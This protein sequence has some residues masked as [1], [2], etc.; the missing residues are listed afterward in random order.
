MYEF[1]KNV[2]LFS[3]LT[4]EDLAHLSHELEEVRLAP[5]EV[6]F[7]EGEPGD[8]AYII[9]SGELEVIKESSGRD[10]LLA[11]RESGEVIGEM[12]LLQDV[13][14]TATVRARSET[15]L[16]ALHKREIDHLLETSVTAARSMF[17]TVLGRIQSM[18]SMLRQS[19]RMAQLGTL[20]A[21]VAHELNNPAAAV[22]RGTSE[23]QATVQKLSESQTSLGC[24]G[25]DDVQQLTLDTLTIDA[26]NLA[27][28]PQTLDALARSDME[29]EI[30]DWLDEHDVD[31]PWELAPT[32]VNLGYDTDKLNRLSGQFNSSNHLPAV[33]GWLSV[34][35]DIHNLLSEI[36]Q[37]V[38]R[39]S[40]IVKALKSYSYL[41]Q[42]PV[43]SV[44]IH[45]GLDDTLLILRNKLKQGVNVIREYDDDLPEI[46]GYGSELNQVWTNLI[47]NAIDALEG[48]GDITLR[49]HQKDDM[50]MVDVEDNGPGIPKEI[51][52]RIFDSFF[53]TKPPG[54]GTGLG[55]DI[56]Y[57]IVVQKH[58]G[59][60]NLDSE[61]GRTT[62]QILL[63]ISIESQ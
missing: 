48:K 49:T 5:G 56:S 24:L 54:K 35:Y 26:R 39:V 33:I 42:A 8:K 1:L 37:G 22:A 14:R 63:P 13:P 46:E 29:Y 9:E 55:L 36:G 7:S 32:L 38:S 57:N 18:E 51:Q 61:P 12:A 19:E 43:Q 21:G 31:D 34:N 17:Y 4:D 41:D 60:L 30:E 6:L 25:F 2:E 52:H 28:K 40:D 44:N 10:V 62:F 27:T 11:V 23:L 59:D 45:Q 50:V 20:T 3:D 47:D 58:R 15:N 16:C 53:T